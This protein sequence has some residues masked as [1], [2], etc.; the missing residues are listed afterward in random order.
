[1]IHSDTLP[2]YYISLRILRLIGP[3]R[4]ISDHIGPYRT[5]SD[6]IGPYRTISD[7]IGPYRTISDHIGPYR[8]ISDHIGPQQDSLQRRSRGLSLS[9]KT[10]ATPKGSRRCPASHAST[11]GSNR[12]APRLSRADVGISE[13]SSKMEQSLS[14][15]KM[16]KDDER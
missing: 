13:M 4:T 5:I 8:T 12:R 2:N 14:Y 1:M 9:E 6:H 3:Y 7:H 16:T 15:G 10:P 11:K